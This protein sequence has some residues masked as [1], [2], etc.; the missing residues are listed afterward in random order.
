ME[1]VPAQPYDEFSPG[2]YSIRIWINGAV[3]N[4]VYFGNFVTHLFYVLT[5]DQ[6]HLCSTTAA[7]ASGMVNDGNYDMLNFIWFKGSE[8]LYVPTGGKFCLS[9]INVLILLL[10]DP[11]CALKG[12][13]NPLQTACLQCKSGYQWVEMKCV[14]EC[15]LG[16]VLH[17]DTNSCQSN[18]N[19]LIA[20]S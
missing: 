3:T 18:F 10:L 1:I 19:Y 17:E 6:I 16:Y 13:I 12:F 14:L 15:P 8:G 11:S 4:R 2:Y 9:Y 7:G 20:L 5:T